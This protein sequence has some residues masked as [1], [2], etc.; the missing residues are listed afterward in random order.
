M[1]VKIYPRKENEK[2]GYLC[3]PMK[4]NIPV[5]R[6]SWKLVNCPECGRECWETPMMRA[7]VK[8]QDVTCLCTECALRKGAAV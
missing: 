2:G 8:Q 5:G 6:T 1:K 3:M 7:L 4:K